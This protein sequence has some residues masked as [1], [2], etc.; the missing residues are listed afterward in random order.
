MFVVTLHN[1]KTTRSA[2][3]VR[4]CDLLMEVYIIM[5]RLLDYDEYERDGEH[6]E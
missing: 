3:V 5:E 6:G 4:F 1:H 2:G